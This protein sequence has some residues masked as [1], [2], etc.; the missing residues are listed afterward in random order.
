LK[1]SSLFWQFTFMLLSLFSLYTRTKAAVLD[2]RATEIDACEDVYPQLAI[3][4]PAPFPSDCEWG[5]WDC[6]I[7]SAVMNHWEFDC[8]SNESW[9]CQFSVHGDSRQGLRCSGS[10][11]APV[12]LLPWHIAA[13]GVFCALLVAGAILGF[14]WWRRRRMRRQLG[15][16]VPASHGQSADMPDEKEDL[17]QFAP[18]SS[19]TEPTSKT[20]LLADD[21]NL[22]GASV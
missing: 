4:C 14:C 9:K 13:I 3:R 18:G 20:R 8:E 22:L 21:E 5:P 16:H 6:R 1:D 2:E 15:A 10:C 19:R 11:E 17:T 7:E 12:K